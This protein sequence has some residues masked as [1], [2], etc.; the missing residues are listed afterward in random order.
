MAKAD[1]KSSTITRIKASSSSSI[2]EKPAMSKKA[3]QQ[4]Q[5]KKARQTPKVLKPFALFLGYFKGAW[6]ELRQVHWPDRKATWSLTLAVILFTVFFIILI[7][8]LDAIF[9]YLFELILG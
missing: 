5:P 2:K 9:K 3:T 1:K 7:V 4:N 6:F 8:I